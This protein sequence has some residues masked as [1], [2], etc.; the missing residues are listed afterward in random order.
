M[1]LE[2]STE[3][4]KK[5]EF[6]NVFPPIKKTKTHIIYKA[7]GLPTTTSTTNMN[8]Q[9]GETKEKKKHTLDLLVCKQHIVC[10]RV[11]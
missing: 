8:N 6:I 3:N 2:I 5:C 9:R 4:S 11:R 10:L 7:A 1:L